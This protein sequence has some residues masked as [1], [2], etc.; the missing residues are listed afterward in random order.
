[1]TGEVYIRGAHATPGAM[2]TPELSPAARRLRARFD[3]GAALTKRQAAKE[4]G[5]VERHVTRVVGELRAAGVAV[6]E[7]RVGRA[8]RFFVP[9][10]HQRRRLEVEA[11]DEEALRALVVAAEAARALLRD[12]PLAGAIDR[13][14]RALLDAAGE[15]YTYTFEA[16]AEV[17]HWHFAAAAPLA[18]NLETLRLLDLAIHDF[19]SVRCDYVNGAGSRT[20]NRKLDPLAL[21]PFKSGWQ[22]AAW[23]HTRRAVRNF[24]PARIERLRL[25]HGDPSGDFFSPPDGWDKDAHFGG[26]FGALE[27]NGRLHTVRLRVA[28][29]VAQHFRSKAY[30]TS[31]TT[32]PGPDGGLVVTFQ[33]RELESMRA[34]VR[35]WGPNV[36]ALEPPE[37]VAG[38]TDDARRTA[39]SYASAAAP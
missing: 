30:H 22:L 7:E 38:L 9:E 26:R 18:Q 23:C 37:L 15:V 36:V 31:Q 13:G 33:V 10:A 29:S 17:D 11:L 2:S 25:C 24:N 16:E 6:E 5:C 3:Q 12:T 19:R 8:K 32:E 35:S 1:M 20:E 4:I 27:G 39:A 21:A 28:Q 34:F 14:F